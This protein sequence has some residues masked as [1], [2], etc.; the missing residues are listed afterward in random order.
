MISNSFQFLVLLTNGKINNIIPKKNC[1]HIVVL[2][3][4][5]HV[6]SVNLCNERNLIPP[7]TVMKV[8]PIHIWS[9]RMAG[10]YRHIL[11]EIRGCRKPPSTHT[12]RDQ[13][14]VSR[15]K[16]DLLYFQNFMT[17]C[18]C[19]LSFKIPLQIFYSII[20]PFYLVRYI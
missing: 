2:P 5:S 10:T 3:F 4:V 8:Q 7:K 9:A 15:G 12:N 6:L 20:S 14:K 17:E 11:I 19:S 13:A 18:C 1:W 16:Q